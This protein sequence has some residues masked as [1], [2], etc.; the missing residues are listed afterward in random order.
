MNYR[1]AEG[2]PRE[3]RITRQQLEFYEHVCHLREIKRQGWVDRGISLEEAE[4]VA[5]HSYTVAVMVGMEAKR[6]GLDGERAMFMALV[7]DLPEIF[8]GDT[9]PYQHLPKGQREQSIDAWT[10][11]SAEAKEDKHRKEEESLKIITQK[12]PVKFRAE[13]VELWQEYDAGETEVAK[14]V[15]QMDH[16]QRLQQAMIYVKQ[17]PD[18][19]VG[20]ILD[21][22]LQ[23]DDPEVKR[24]AKE[25]GKIVKSNDQ[26]PA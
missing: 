3:D 25:L 21:Q 18:F 11:P 17:K 13:I 1:E 24:V 4:T 9:T 5:D 7:H 19:Q 12:L 6:R 14:L 8:A 26:A 23:S 15:R 20:S 10:A 22:G 2:R 16:I